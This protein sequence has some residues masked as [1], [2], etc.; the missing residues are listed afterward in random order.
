MA[1]KRRKKPEPVAR[2]CQ[3]LSE[4]YYELQTVRDTLKY[5]TDGDLYD[6]CMPYIDMFGREDLDQFYEKL[7]QGGDLEDDERKK[8]EAFYILVSTELSANE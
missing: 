8:L 5:L 7:S 2:K 4:V 1:V 3:D 6:C